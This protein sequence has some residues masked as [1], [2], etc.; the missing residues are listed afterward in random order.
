MA[1]TARKPTSGTPATCT[2]NNGTVTATPIEFGAT[3]LISSDR[4]EHASKGAIGALI[5][6]PADATWTEGGTGCVPPTGGR[7]TATFADVSSPSGPITSFREFVLLFQ[8]DVNM[9][10]DLEMTP[11]CDVPTGGVVS[12][13]GAPV[14][15]LACLD[16]AED[17]G[18]KALN[19]RTEPLWKRMQI[20]PGTPFEETRDRTDWWNVVSNTKVGSI[21][22]DPQTPVF[23]ATS[24]Q[25]IRFRILEP[26][27]HQRNHVFALHGHI[28]DREPY[29]QSSTKIGRNNFSFW[30]GARMGHGPSNHF[31]A[32]IR[33][34]AGGKFSVVGDFLFRDQVAIGFD[35]GLWGILRVVP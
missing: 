24:N 17:S 15:N 35:N 18:Q 34:E 9:R 12:G 22:T 7:C 28:W 3:N 29:I 26:G 32:L 30:E 27:G 11:R 10:T 33:H 20:P 23:Q 1:P 2:I 14:E 13:H 31:D 6:E 21:S 8:N 25:Q 5:I 16:D 4:I 19:Y